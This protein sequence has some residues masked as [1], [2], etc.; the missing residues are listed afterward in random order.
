MNLY[1]I[2]HISYSVKT[3]KQNTPNVTRHANGL[4]GADPGFRDRGV[5]EIHCSCAQWFLDLSLN[6]GWRG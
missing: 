6:A 3:Y 2:I 5:L 4:S 1:N